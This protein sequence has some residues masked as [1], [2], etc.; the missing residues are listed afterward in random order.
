MLAHISTVDTANDLERVR[1]ALGEDTISYIGFSYGSELGATYA[2]LFPK[3]IRAM[4]LDGAIDPDLDGVETAHAQAIGAE[5]AL[6]SFLADCSSHRTCAFHNNGNAEGAYD[7][8]MSELDANPLPP[9]EKGRPEVGQGVALN[10]VIQALYSS[11]LWPSLAE[12][13][14]RRAARRRR[15]PA[16]VQRLVPRARRQRHVEQHDRGVHRDQLP[17][18]SGAD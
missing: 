11:D 7:T 2:T 17:R 6:D 9:P 16:R 14:E 15:R 3:H 12:A 5:H 18:R 10:A 4:V 13:L 8:L 1:Q